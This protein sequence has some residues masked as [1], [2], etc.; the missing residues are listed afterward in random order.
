[1]PSEISSS[2][3][4]PQIE[5]ASNIDNLNHVFLC[6]RPDKTQS[7]QIYRFR[8]Q[9]ILVVVEAEIFTWCMF[10]HQLAVSVQWKNISQC[11]LYPI[12][13]RLERQA[14]IIDDAGKR[15]I[16]GFLVRGVRAYRKHELE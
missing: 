10:G 3:S 11:F 16:Q 8:P 13:Y 12:N 14:I 15:D 4:K 7:N 6:D 9:P 5:S 1:M 2:R